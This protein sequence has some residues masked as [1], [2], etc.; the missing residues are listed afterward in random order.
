LVWNLGRNPR[1]VGCPPI[2]GLQQIL[3]KFD[4]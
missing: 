1:V 4:L 2:R 3:K